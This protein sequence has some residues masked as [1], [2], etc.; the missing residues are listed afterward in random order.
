MVF[1]S[2][3]LQAKQKLANEMAAHQGAVNSAAEVRASLE[4][5]LQVQEQR[6]LDLDKQN[7]MLHHQVQ[8][9]VVLCVAFESFY[10]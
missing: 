2:P 1:F 5:Q 9:F 8:C 10:C 4:R 7:S 3:F 6:L